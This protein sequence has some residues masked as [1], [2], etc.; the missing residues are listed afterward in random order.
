M[1]KSAVTPLPASAVGQFAM[2]DLHVQEAV[3][4]LL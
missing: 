2:Q 1:H 3:H 4:D